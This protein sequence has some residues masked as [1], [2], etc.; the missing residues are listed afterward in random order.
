MSDFGVLYL[1]DQ[2]PHFLRMLDVSLQSLR[3]FHPDWPVEIRR[4]ES[5]PV[6]FWKRLYRR[7]SFWKI[8]K[9]RAR[10]FQDTRIIGRKAQ[11]MAATPFRH[12]LFLDAD[13][14]VMKPLDDLRRRAQ[15]ADVLVTALPWKS[16]SGVEDWQPK[17]FPY[18][19]S[20]VVFYSRRFAEE[21]RPYVERLAPRV[22]SLPTLDQ[23]VF[24][25]ACHLESSRLKILLEPSLQIDVINL[26]QHLEER[27]CPRHGGIVDLSCESLQ[28]FH[29]F[30]YNEDKD[31]Y[32]EEIG[33]K[34][35]LTPGSGLAAEGQP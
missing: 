23:Y 4:L 12:T 32:L 21:Y 7:V 13:T 9:R 35:D 8:D 20:G 5:L 27:E 1:V 3:R 26:D 29:V 2:N 31:R 28:D 16:Y 14:V 19:C 25:L 6:P 10:G 34:W 30:H 24:S 17:S 22:E 15:G 33:K 11:A 18:L